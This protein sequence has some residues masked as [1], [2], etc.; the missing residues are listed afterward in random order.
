MVA[1]Y[2]KR[3]DYTAVAKT[4]HWL[5]AA[6]IFVMFPLAWTMG[7]FSG[8]QKFKLYNLHKSIGISILALIALRLLWRSFHTPPALPA[9]VPRRERVVAHLWHFALY[10]ALFLMPLSGWAM[11][12]ASDKPSVLFGWTAF[13]LIHW[14]SELPAE[15]KK[16]YAHFFKGVHEFTANVLLLLIVIHVAAA[17]RHAFVLRDGIMSR[18]LPRFWRR[19]VS[20]HT[21]LLVLAASALSFVGLRDA[22]AMEWSVNP[23][24]SEVIFEA[25]GGGYNTQ[26]IFKSYKTEIDFDP[27]TPD[28]ATV[29]VLLD[30]RSAST[31]AADADQTL[32]SAEFFDPGH[33]P[34][35]EFAA[36]GAKPDGDGKYILNGRL[37]L[38]GVTK[39]VSLP[40]SIDIAEGTAAIKAQATINRLDFGV[41]PQ[42]VAGLAVD[43]EV[44]LTIE[45]SAMR[46]DD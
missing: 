14:L 7:D 3:K 19:S 30:M 21:A 36:R 18:M 33:Y 29:H 6:L 24:K 42:S 40:F 2:V 46:L 41:G 34:T 1:P 4:L 44:K 5:I 12:S 38:K 45:L 10:A 43:K 32:Q 9:S 31:G 25:S 20:R 35:A 16:E 15:Q 23:Q 37:T 26:G 22:A 28:Q 39:P 27:E 11:I 8:I 17:L 13:P